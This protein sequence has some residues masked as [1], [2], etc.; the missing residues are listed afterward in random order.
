M[1]LSAQV[2]IDALE[3]GRVDDQLARKRERRETVYLGAQRATAVLTDQSR[4]LPP[5]A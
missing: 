3:R 2:V 1:N 5:S 4:P